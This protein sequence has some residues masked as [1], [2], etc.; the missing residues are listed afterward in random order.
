MYDLQEIEQGLNR[1]YKR[2][3]H[4][5]CTGTVEGEGTS[6]YYDMVPPVIDVEFKEVHEPEYEH[7]HKDTHKKRTKRQSLLDRVIAAVW[8]KIVITVAASAVLWFF[9]MA[10]MYVVLAAVI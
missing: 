9:A 3:Q 6:R 1:Y 5:A 4:E 8:C 10:I 7:E 2:V